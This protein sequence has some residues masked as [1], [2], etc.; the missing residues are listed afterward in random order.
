MFSFR[1]KNKVYN[2][3]YAAGAEEARGKILHKMDDGAGEARGKILHKMDVGR[4][5]SFDVPVFCCILG[6]WEDHLSDLVLVGF[7][8]EGVIGW[9]KKLLFNIITFNID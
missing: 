8:P 6:I 5:L 3:Y 1:D 9:S 4:S 2:V 7:V